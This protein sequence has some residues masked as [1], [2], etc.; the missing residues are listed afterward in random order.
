MA[1]NSEQPR[2]SPKGARGDK[3]A[4][5]AQ[6][7]LGKAGDSK[8]RPT[9]TFQRAVLAAMRAQRPMVIAQLRLLTKKYPHDTPEELAQRLGR[10]YIGS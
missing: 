5:R 6:K 7:L 3:A 8:G 4:K 1:K 10:F 2:K 9:P